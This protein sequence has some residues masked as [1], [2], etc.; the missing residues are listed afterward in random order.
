MAKPA[1]A[2]T[3]ILN[4]SYEP[5]AVVPLRRAVVLVLLERA[6]VVST[7]GTYSH[8]ERFLIENPSVIRLTRFVRVPYTRRVPVTRRNVLA[9]DSHVCAYCVLTQ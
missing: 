6:E 7:D 2:R 3:L 8:S 1:T 5:L 9:R 4:A